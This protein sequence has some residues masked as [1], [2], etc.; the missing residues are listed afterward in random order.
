[1]LKSSDQCLYYLL[2]DSAPI[3]N[4]QFQLL[5]KTGIDF[6]QGSRTGTELFFAELVQGCAAGT[7]GRMQVLASGLEVQQTCKDFTTAV[8][9]LLY[10]KFDP[11]VLCS[12]FFRGIIGQRPAAAMAL[13]FD[14]RHFNP[15]FY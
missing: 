3:S 7:E 6:C 12:S 5:T 10:H 15:F 1:M 8:G 13:Y 14:A 11:S 9:L 2:F 4:K